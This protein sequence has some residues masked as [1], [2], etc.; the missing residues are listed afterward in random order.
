MSDSTTP[1][2]LSA[3]RTPIG[4]YLGGLSSFSAPQLGAITIR[5]AVRRAGVDAALIDEVIMGHVLQGGS[6]QAPGR[7]AAIKVLS[8]QLA[9]KEDFVK[10]FYREAR[11]MA[12]MNHDNAVSSSI[13]NRAMLPK[14]RHAT[15]KGAKCISRSTIFA[16]RA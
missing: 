14:S 12:K 11:A 3:C 15:A 13:P 1:V 9:G 2:I 7:Q 5:E 6:G 8:K 10:R 4:K 16:L